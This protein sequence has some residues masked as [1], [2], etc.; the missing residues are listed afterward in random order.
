MQCFLIECVRAMGYEHKTVRETAAD[1]PNS[2]RWRGA[3][4]A[5]NQSVF[6]AP[7]RSALDAMVP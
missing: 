1:I 3:E 7:R 4:D 5:E 2:Q 6:P